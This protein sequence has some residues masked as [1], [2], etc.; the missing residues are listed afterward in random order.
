MINQLPPVVVAHVP[1][2]DG[3]VLEVEDGEMVLLVGATVEEAETVVEAG[4]LL[5]PEDG[6]D[7]E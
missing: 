4:L 6:L 2:D 7:E 3:Q 5:G 1:L